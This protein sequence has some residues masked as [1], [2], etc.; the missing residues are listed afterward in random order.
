VV[1]EGARV[2]GRLVPGDQAGDRVAGVGV[3]GGELP[4]R[5]DAVELADIEGV[6]GDQ[7]AGPGGEVAEPERAVLGWAGEDAGRV[8]TRPSHLLGQVQRPSD[9]R[10]RIN[11][12]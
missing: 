3:D 9:L 2:S 1:D 7:V 12:S 11:V 10:K 8:E 6:Q 4:D 5:A